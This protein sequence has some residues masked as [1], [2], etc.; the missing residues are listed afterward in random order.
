MSTPDNLPRTD[1]TN[2]FLKRSSRVCECNRL[3]ETGPANPRY[4]LFMISPWYLSVSLRSLSHRCDG[5]LAGLPQMVE[6]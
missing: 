3:Q 1:F 2:A 6:W 4:G 5:H